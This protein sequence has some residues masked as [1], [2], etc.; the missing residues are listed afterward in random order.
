MCQGETKDSALSQTGLLN[1]VV[2]FKKK[3]YR[4]AWAKYELAKAETISLMPPDQALAS[5]ESDYA[6]M[7]N[8]IFGETPP[9]SE[10]LECIG[11]LEKEIHRMCR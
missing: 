3:F 11:N 8:M 10:I 5:L 6:H 1:E 4:C 2:E 9:F 7:R